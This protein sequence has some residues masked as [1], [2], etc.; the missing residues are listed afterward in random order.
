MVFYIN[1]VK[2]ELGSNKTYKRIVLDEMSV[3]DRHRWHMV[4]K[5]DVLVE[6]EHDKF[7]A[8]Y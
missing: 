6:E 3:V 5:F 4:A 1:T 2:Q 7:Y 8:I